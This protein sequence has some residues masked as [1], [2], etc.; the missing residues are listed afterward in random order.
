MNF[1]RSLKFYLA[2]SIIVIMA[3]TLVVVSFLNYYN[4]EKDL[5]GFVKSRF[6]VIAKDLKGTVEYGLNLGLGVPELRNVQHIVEQIKA[7]DA[8]IS[9]VFIL[10]MDG[11]I[12]FHSDPQRIG[13]TIVAKD[14]EELAKSDPQGSLLKGDRDYMT[15]MPLLNN[16]DVREGILVVAYPSRLLEQPKQD[17]IQFLL[18][19]FLIIGGIFAVLA[20]LV[21]S[22]FAALFLR[23]LDHLS[24]AL[25]KL[26][27]GVPFAAEGQSEPPAGGASEVEN[28]YLRFHETTAG[29]LRRLRALEQRLDER[30]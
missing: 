22:F 9:S 15:T 2:L 25:S 23:T 20:F 21:I 17:M 16:F 12:L 26:L 4:F 1:L 5:D 27:Q 24:E 13:Q 14:V 28:K 30:Y 29:L 8:D 11:R 3:F 7:S 10:D 6:L 18:Q 19:R